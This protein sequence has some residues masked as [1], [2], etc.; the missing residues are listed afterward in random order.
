[1]I[2][3]D[4]SAILEMLLRTPGAAAIEARVFRR[5]ETLHTP[6]LLDVEVA[7]VLRRYVSRGE[8]APGRARSALDLLLG[9]PMERYTHEPLLSRI[10]DLRTTLT[11]YDAAYVALAEGLR[12]PLVTC[13]ARLANAPGIRAAVELFD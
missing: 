2:V 13:D 6:A 4:A 9:F 8:V 3:A 5:G 7:Q 10:W 12:A 11:A 1:M